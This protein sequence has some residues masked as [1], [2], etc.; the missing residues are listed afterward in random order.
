MWKILKINME[1]KNHLSGKKDIFQTCIFGVPTC[2]FSGVYTVYRWLLVK[3][4]SIHIGFGWG[5][6]LSIALEKEGF[7]PNR[8]LAGELFFWGSTMSAPTVTMDKIGP[9][10]M[11]RLLETLGDSRFLQFFRVVSS[12][13][14]KPRFPTQFPV[15]EFL[16]KGEVKF[17]FAG[18]W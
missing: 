16:K 10:K 8:C 5:T 12:D 14:G 15:G 1:P 6:C 17:R 13:Y 2:K 3:N 4:S 7:V 11:A 9:L 18:S